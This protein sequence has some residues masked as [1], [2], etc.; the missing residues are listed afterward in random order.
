VLNGL[1][2]AQLATFMVLYLTILWTLSR[3][4]ALRLVVLGV[5]A[6]W[7]L[8][9][10]FFISLR[11]ATPDQSREIAWVAELIAVS[12]AGF[13]FSW[14]YIAHVRCNNSHNR[15]SYKAL[16]D[17]VP[18]LLHR[19]DKPFTSAAAAQLWFEW[20]RAGQFLPVLVAFLLLFVILPV[21]FLL[22]HQPASTISI[23]IGVLALPT[24]LALPVGKGFSKPEFWSRDLSFPAFL[25]VR[26]LAADEIIA[27][28]LRAAA[29]SAVVSWALTVGFVLVWLPFWADLTIVSMAR[30]FLWEVYGAAIYPIVGLFIL[31]G[32]FVTW[33]F[34][35]GGLW[36]GLSGNR[37]LYA[38][39][40]LPYSLAPIL[41]LY[42]LLAITRQ[43][44]ALR[45]WIRSQP[46]QALFVLEC[47]V[48]AALVIKLLVVAATWSRNTSRWLRRYG[49]VWAL[50]T[51]SM[52]V[53]AILIWSGARQI[54]SPGTSRLKDVLILSALVCV[55]IARVS[56][57]P[58]FLHH[59]RHR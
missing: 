48:A 9:I 8:S 29:V 25:S 30:K 19:R 46:D 21:S 6:F 31:A 13:L 52:V 59:N 42:A 51:V 11:Q 27:I 26:P 32:I 2:A 36:I 37:H 55:P 43:N 40:V 17:W 28:K 5:I 20:R 23:L 10:S 45:V 14:F 33:R 34:L 3:F 24:L 56:L 12:I 15:W 44:N 4:G 47:L 49:P 39:T 16:V 1:I 7:L 54:L 22:R 18:R 57:A 58:M 35:V 38:T 41:L 50:S 53:L